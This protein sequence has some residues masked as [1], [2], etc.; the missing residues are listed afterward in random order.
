MPYVQRTYFPDTLHTCTDLIFSHCMHMYV[1]TSKYRSVY[2]LN[3]FHITI[4]IIMRNM[5]IDNNI[6]IYYSGQGA[7]LH[8][9][10]T[11][12]FRSASAIPSTTDA[13]PTVQGNPCQCVWLRHLVIRASSMPNK[14]KKKQ[15]RKKRASMFS[16]AGLFFLE[17]DRNDDRWQWRLA[18]ELRDPRLTSHSLNKLLC[19]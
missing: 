18:S 8:N 15:Q 13:P 11:T 19:T 1:H 17:W 10:S 2:I 9:L 14:E 16:C 7:A 3:T 4:I 6:N 12:S 5:I